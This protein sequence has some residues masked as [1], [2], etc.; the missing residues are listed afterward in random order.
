MSD[1]AARCAPLAQLNAYIRETVAARA[2]PPEPGEPEDADELPSVRRFRRA[3]VRTH[4][5][6]Q[7]T[8]A[9]ARRP[10]QAGPLNSHLLVLQLLASLRDLSPDYLRRLL[11]H[12][13]TLQWLEQAV[14]PAVVTPRPAR[15]RPAP[16]RPRE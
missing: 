5:Q 10:A 16:R 2:L 6:D 13:E 7:V 8:Q 9:V 14:P 4:S 3:W 12:V 1:D 11:L 15:K